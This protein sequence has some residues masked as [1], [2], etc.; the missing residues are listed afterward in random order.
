M[1]I[2]SLYAYAHGPCALHLTAS[3][4]QKAN[5]GRGGL[6]CPSCS[7]TRTSSQEEPRK[8]A[9]RLFSSTTVPYRGEGYSLFLSFFGTGLFLLGRARKKRW[10]KIKR[11]IEG[12]AQIPLVRTLERK[13]TNIFLMISLYR[14]KID[15]EQAFHS[16]VLITVLG[17]ISTI[18][19]FLS[20]LTL[21]PLSPRWQN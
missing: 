14:L 3:A 8:E 10:E 15:G 11:K 9:F 7:M 4:R 6:A 21:P 17:H 16:F 13:K 1:H 20:H 12:D 2:D 5:R 19:Y 18:S